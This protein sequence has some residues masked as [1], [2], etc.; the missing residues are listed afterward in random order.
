M[1]FEYLKL[2]SFGVQT[3]SNID[4]AE[5]SNLKQQHILLLGNYLDGFNITLL[6]SVATVY[7][8]P[9][10]LEWS[11][12]KDM[13]VRWSDLHPYVHFNKHKSRSNFAYS[14]VERKSLLKLLL[15]G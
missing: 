2:M 8:L 15:L 3:S 7:K 12:Q 13:E 10:G 1:K 6:F 11:F 9:F 5:K 4:V 14:V